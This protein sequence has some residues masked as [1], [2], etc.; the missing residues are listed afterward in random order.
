MCVQYESNHCKEEGLL[1]ESIEKSC[2]PFS[3]ANME[4]IP[5]LMLPS[6]RCRRSP[7]LVLINGQVLRENSL[8]SGMLLYITLSWL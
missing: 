6:E 5:A 3:Y 2:A 7:V 8:Q 1:L 4:L